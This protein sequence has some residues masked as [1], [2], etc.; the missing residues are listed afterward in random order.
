VEAGGG[1]ADEDVADFDFFSGDEFVAVNDSD[2]EAGEIVFALDVKAGHLRGFATDEGAAVG[3]AGVGESGDDFFGDLGIEAAGG[4]VVEEEERGRA[5]DGDVVDAVIH[6]VGA[7]G[8]VDFEGEGEFELG[9]DSVGGGDEDGIF[10]FSGVEFEEAAEAADVADDG[11]IEGALGEIFDALFGAVSDGDVHARIGIGH[12]SGDGV[13]PI[14]G[15][16]RGT[17]GQVGP[18]R[19]RN[20]GRNCW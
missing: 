18:I 5:L 10:P 2:D 4:E 16:W 14:G 12:R 6:E 7:D 13:W 15:R 8:V 1:E 9:A 11:T 17:S 3:A 20:V 19:Q